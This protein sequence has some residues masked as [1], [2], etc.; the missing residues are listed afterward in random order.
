MR[1]TQIRC[2]L[3]CARYAK[4]HNEGSCTLT[5]INLAM[6]LT[7]GSYIDLGSSS[8]SLSR[9]FTNVVR[10]GDEVTSAAA[11]AVVTASALG[12]SVQLLRLDLAGSPLAPGSDYDLTLTLRT[13]G[14][15]PACV[16]GKLTLTE[17]QL[18]TCCQPQCSR[19]ST[20]TACG[21]DGCGGTCGVCN[22][23]AGSGAQQVCSD[24]GVCGTCPHARFLSAACFCRRDALA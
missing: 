24:I 5:S 19:G 12:Y 7:N 18:S 2:I 22:A 6:Q 10:V 14:G 23:D 17:A 4:L 1:S 3:W 21:S 11:A 9:A 16:P 13:D 15:V 20:G 8:P